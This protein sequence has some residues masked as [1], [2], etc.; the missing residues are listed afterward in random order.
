VYEG[1]CET[2]RVDLQYHVIFVVAVFAFKCGFIIVQVIIVAIIII[3]F[4]KVYGYTLSVVEFHY[5][6]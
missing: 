6:I 1:V 2:S 4:S 5:T 3:W